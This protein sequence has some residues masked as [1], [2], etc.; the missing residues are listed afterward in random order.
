MPDI[1]YCLNISHC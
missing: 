1:G